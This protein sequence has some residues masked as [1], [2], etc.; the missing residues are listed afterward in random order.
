MR[1]C[2]NFMGSYDHEHSHSQEKFKSFDVAFAKSKNEILLK[3]GMKGKQSLPFHQGEKASFVL[4]A[5]L[6][7]HFS[8]SRTP[9]SD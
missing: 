8:G 5:L 6:A 7:M 1:C 9:L 2:A 3:S 4:G